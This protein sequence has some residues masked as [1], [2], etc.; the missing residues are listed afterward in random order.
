[1]TQQKSFIDIVNH[2]IQSDTVTLPV[3]SAAASRVQQELAK[4]E[5]D[6]RIIERII[7]ADQSLSSQVLKTANSAFYKGLSE[8]STI[9][10]AIIRLGVKEIQKI[11][12]LAATRNT[13]Q[14]KDKLINLIVKKLWQH[15]VGCAY[16]AV[17]ICKRHD[18]DV[19]PSKAFFGGLFHDVGKLFILMVIE[20]I[21]QKNKQTKI[22]PSLIM[23]SMVKLH[24]TQGYQLLKHWNVPNQF[25]VVARDHHLLDIDQE[26]TLLLIVRMANQVC[27]KLGINTEPSQDI[28][29]SA[30]MEANLL[31]I[32]EMDIA[33]LEIYL[34]DSR[35]LTA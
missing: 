34:E 1:M 11:V 7:T 32:S 17:W 29:L 18:Y 16:G 27:C 4:K 23:E 26:N 5:P 10:N 13:F 12:L 19:D 9:R 33:E 21:K 28:M 22:T 6:I 14:C 20:H 25:A 8:I 35:V 24:T 31:N 2:Y 15:S 30:T 3:F